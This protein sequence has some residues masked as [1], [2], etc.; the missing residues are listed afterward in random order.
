M[1]A[2]IKRPD[3]AWEH[4]DIIPNLANLQEVVGGYIEAVPNSYTDAII[5]ADEEGL[6]KDS[7]INFAVYENPYDDEPIAHIVGTVIML[8]PRDEEGNETDLTMELFEKTIKCIE[9]L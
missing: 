8:G 2:A 4:V 5:Y 3:Q 6:L 7:Q 9:A 1:K